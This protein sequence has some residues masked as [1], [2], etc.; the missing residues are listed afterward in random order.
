MVILDDADADAD[1][2]RMVA[3]KV[4]RL[5]MVLPEARSIT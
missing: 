4:D 3:G 5:D 2:Y 1:T